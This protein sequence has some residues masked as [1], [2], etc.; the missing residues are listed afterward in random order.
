MASLFTWDMVQAIIEQ[1]H[2]LGHLAGK[3]LLEPIH[4]EWIH[5][6]HDTKEDRILQAS[7][8]SY[9]TTAVCE[10]GIMY[11]LMRDPEET[12]A[13][14]R[15]SYTAAAEVVRAVMN[16]MESPAIHELFRFI[17][18]ADKTGKIPPKADWYFDTRKEGKINLSIRKNHTPEC[19]V[20]A[21]GLDS[22]ITGRH[23][24]YVIMDDVTDIKDRMFTAE[25]EYTKT[26]VSE[27]RANI[28]NR[29]GNASLMG[30]AWHREDTLTML[31]DQGL[32]ARVYPYQVLP[33]ISEAHI[34]EAKKAQTPALFA[35]N[36]ELK[37]NNTDDALFKDAYFDKWDFAHAK[38][39]VCHVD[40]AYGGDDFTA[41]TIMGNIGNG[42]VC[43]VGWVFQKHCQ[44]CILFIFDKCSQYKARKIIA[45]NNADK[46]FFLDL[47]AKHPL[48][49]AY[50]IFTQGYAESMNK[51]I[52]ITTYVFEKWRNIQWAPETDP[53]YMNQILDYNEFTKDHDDAPDSL[54]SIIREGG[55]SLENY[56]GLYEW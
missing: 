24:K 55:F 16:M 5:Y 43:A 34:E 35:C 53:V 46:G 4:S 38:D 7:R 22:R 14:V 32:P 27:I 9:K 2:L 6:I 50:G 56:M 3:T 23:Y 44:D 18:F 1:P 12:I 36:Y 28:V 48:S 52:K 54:A 10:I 41:I 49:A 30:T 21:L 42:K 20:E 40:C 17:F 39:I 29:D 13:V 37:F 8:G 25:R 26:I 19:S 33:F 45:E 51:Q 31:K 15:K 11:R 47:L